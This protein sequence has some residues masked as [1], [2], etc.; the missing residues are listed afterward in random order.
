M[1]RIFGIFLFIPLYFLAMLSLY[2]V[3]LMNYENQ[4]VEEFRLRKAVNYAID[5]ATAEM[6]ETGDLGMDYANWGKIT[7]NPGLASEAFANSFCINYGMQT[8]QQN[9]D[10]VQMAYTKLFVVCAYDGYYVY[11][12]KKVSEDGTYKFTSTPKL[13]YSYHKGNNTYALNLGLVDCWRFSSNRKL[14]K[15]KSPLSEKETLSQINRHISDDFAYRL[16]QQYEH[17]WSKSLYIPYEVTTVS[18]TNS[19]DRPS[20]LAFIDDVDIVSAK[21][22]S[23]FGVGGAHVTQN[24]SVAAYKRN[25]K[26]YYSYADLL[27]KDMYTATN[28]DGKKTFI[29]EMYMTCQEAA[30]AGYYHDTLYMN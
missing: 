13:P 11:S 24:R 18:S 25:G 15:V 19:I 9:R 30:E 29:E 12:P 22:I 20:V 3:T 23:A 14:A 5:A 16:D 4:S 8:N 6:L 26:K 1:S 21:S 27:P 2:S 7:V 10:L 28:P 17:G